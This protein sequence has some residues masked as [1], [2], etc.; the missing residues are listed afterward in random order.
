MDASLVVS[1]SESPSI[2]TKTETRNGVL[3]CAQGEDFFA[4]SGIPD[5]N[6]LIFAG[7]CHPVSD[8]AEDQLDD[9]L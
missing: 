6:R 9:R 2:V 4:G 8:R 1:G 5:F 7:R 3:M